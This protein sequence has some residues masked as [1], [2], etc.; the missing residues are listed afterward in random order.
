[1]ATKLTIDNPGYHV[2][3]ATFSL[4]DDGTSLAVLTGGPDHTQAIVLDADQI[5]Q[6]RQ[7]LG[8]DKS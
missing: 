7:L 4:S 1:M 5:E 6:L 3:H 2:D 8:E